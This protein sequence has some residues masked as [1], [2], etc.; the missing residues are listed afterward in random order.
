MNVR[1]IRSVAIEVGVQAAVAGGHEVMFPSARQIHSAYPSGWQMNVH[2]SLP[3][4]E[5]LQPCL[6][7][8][9]S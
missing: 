4:G 6:Q 2:C 5:P 1:V 7:S 8:D 9:R 3:Q